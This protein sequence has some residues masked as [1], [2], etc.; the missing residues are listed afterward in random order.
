MDHTKYLKSKVNNSESS[1]SSAAA[2]VENEFQELVKEKTNSIQNLLNSIDAILARLNVLL[3]S[4]NLF[5]RNRDEINSIITL[6]RNLSE[7]ISIQFKEADDLNDKQ[8]NEQLKQYFSSIIQMLK[9]KFELK[10]KLF[11]QLL[12]KYKKTVQE[13]E[14]RRRQYG[15]RQVMY[16]EDDDIN[17]KAHMS[18]TNVN[19]I[20]FKPPKPKTTLRQ[21]GS[22]VLDH[23]QSTI[24][25]VSRLFKNMATLV[26]HQEEML[27]RIDLT[28]EEGYS[29]FNLGQK[30]LQKYYRNLKRKSWFFFKIFLIVLF[31]ATILFLMK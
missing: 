7:S 31:F 24:A 17:A 6:A 30:H 13:L 16:Q 9:Q 1:S 28:L 18:T 11:T 20:L 3:G 2:G 8:K 12:C 5:N 4:S 14:S 25:D 19:S 27:T 21:A 23:I 15:K 29:Q 26:S 10:T 22:D